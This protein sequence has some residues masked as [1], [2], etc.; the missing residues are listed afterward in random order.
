MEANNLKDEYKTKFK[1]IKT[2]NKSKKIALIVPYMG[3]S[4]ILSFA[5]CLFYSLFIHRQF[6]NKSNYVEII[7]MFAVLAIMFVLLFVYEKYVTGQRGDKLKPHLI[8]AVVSFVTLALSIF[9]IKTVSEFFVPLMF[10]FLACAA[11]VNTRSAMFNL[12]V[13]A[14]ALFFIILNSGIFNESTASYG[15]LFNTIAGT[16][17]VFALKWNYKRINIIVLNILLGSVAAVLV[18]VYALLTNEFAESEALWLLVSV[19]S[20]VFLFICLLP[21]FDRMFDVTTDFRIAEYLTLKNPV[22]KYLREKAP[23]TYNHSLI[24]ATL[25]ESCAE[26]IGENPLLARAAAYYHDVGKTKAPEFF[27][28]NQFDGYNPH[29]ELIPEV[30][31]SKIIAHTKNGV[32]MLKEKHFPEEII[33]AA[34]E[35]HGTSPV[36]FFYNKAKNMTEGGRLSAGNYTY[37]NQKPSS[38]ISALIMICDTVESAVRANQSSDIPEL[39]KKLVDDKIALGQFSECDISLK[40]I[41]IIERTLLDTIP[42]VFHSRV[43]Y[44]SS[45]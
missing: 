31:A 43:R 23:G 17:T 15:V 32:Q 16:L 40:D 42:Q 30:S 25:A 3:V 21:L 33:K 26:A 36:N 24:V 44:G 34:E 28:E 2:A 18:Y 14:F 8:S 9:F 12:F 41:D 22:L 10:L 37:D 13:N 1:S 38:K 35:H 20:S 39:I 4:L 29:D 7:S 5:F 11:L 6:F 45:K 27:S 19:V